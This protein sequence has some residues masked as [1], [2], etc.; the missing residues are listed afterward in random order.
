MTVRTRPNYP[1]TRRDEVVEDL[2]GHR[3]ED[4]YRWL[5]DPNDPDT[6]A[7]VEAQNE[8]TQAYLAEL[9]D[10]EWFSE[11]MLRVVGRPRTGV[12][13]MRGGRHLV[14]RNDGLQDQDVWYVADSLAELLEGG[15]VLVDPNTFTAAGTDS[16]GSLTVSPDGRVACYGRS[17]GGSDWHTFVLLDL[18]TGEEIEDAVIQTKFSEATW[19]PDSRSYLYVDFAHDG[20]AEGT[21]ADALGGATLRLHRIGQPQNDDAVLLAF[22]DNDQLIM[23]PQLTHDRRYVVVTIVE[24]TE[25]RNRLWVY[26]VLDQLGPSTLGGAIRLIDEPLAEVAFVRSVGSRF[27]LLTDL[28]APRGRVVSCDIERFERTGLTELIQLIAEGEDTIETV[29]AA[30]DVLLS[31]GLRDAAPVLRRYALDG[32][33]LGEIEV[34]G[35]AVTALNADV[36]EPHA[37][38][39]LS[40][41]V[42]P[43]EVYAVD[44]ATGAATPLPGLVRG[45]AGAF[46]PP[47]VRVERRRAVS[48]D[49]TQVPYFLVLP[50]VA[51]LS[52]PTP[53]L[54]Y[55]YGGFK[56]P[57]PADYRPGWSAWLAAGGV[58]VIANLRG[59]GEFGTEWYDQGRL[60]SK[61]NV[62]DD[63]IAVAEHLVQ[64]GVT[65]PEQLAVHGRSNGG[66]LVGAVITQRPDLFAAAVPGVGVLDLLRFHL[67][68]IGAA[69]ISDYGD[70]RD[71]AQFVDALAYSP[72][73]NVRPGTAYPATLV[74]TGDHDDRVVPLHSHKFTAALQH[75]QTGDAPVL[76]RIET[77]T[78]HGL[79]KPA[80]MVAAEWADLLAF[81][82]DRT[83]LSVP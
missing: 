23:W 50:A 13:M 15:R 69:W 24:G 46:V 59:G 20:H 32:S 36:G 41:V 9:P 71:P 43:T 51:D 64:T 75:A 78:G 1:R 37:F 29:V 73:H 40:S 12:P 17:E 10:R 38:V 26:P 68:T 48:P 25:N 44:A 30:G 19:L 67:F 18:D 7:W 49:G 79:G 57:I 82:A 8:I 70:P 21:R 62:F 42:S 56:V 72:L 54:L 61:Q 16:V 35:G 34:T 63:L 22:P 58:L 60:G 5:E 31:S 39:G 52:T 81:C 14:T 74:L 2:H 4:P 55:G 27:V 53:T 6:M 66:L 45:D 47:A 3:I 77:A 33:P 80:A 65:S 28:E 76:T 83:G 11:T